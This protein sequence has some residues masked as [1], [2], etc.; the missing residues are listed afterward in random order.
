MEMHVTEKDLCV[1]FQRIAF[2]N[3]IL[4]RMITV[5]DSDSSGLC[6]CSPPR[7]WLATTVP[8][9]PDFH[10]TNPE[11]RLSSCCL[12]AG[13]SSPSTPVSSGSSPRWWRG[14]Q[15]L[16]SDSNTDSQYQMFPFGLIQLTV[17]DYQLHRIG[18]GIS[19]FSGIKCWKSNIIIHN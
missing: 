19:W 7:R 2:M 12:T 15:V 11:W 17:L 8:W 10:L 13:T 16:F 18:E 1:E 14:F 5:L 4:K 9:R 6:L 3:A